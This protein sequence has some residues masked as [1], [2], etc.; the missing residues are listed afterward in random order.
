MIL[1]SHENFIF[2]TSYRRKFCSHINLTNY[3]ILENFL[4]L[5]STS[6]Q[7]IY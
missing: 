4:K 5:K 6:T 3:T 2:N 7:M 1:K